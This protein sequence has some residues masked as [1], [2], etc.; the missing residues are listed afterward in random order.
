MAL[1]QG[2]WR[3]AKLWMGALLCVG[4]A[5]ATT[6]SVKSSDLRGF[7]SDG[8]AGALLFQRCEAGGPAATQMLLRDKSAGSLLIAG[9]GEVRRARQD[10]D[11]PLYVEFRGDVEEKGATA[12]QFYRAIGH[13]TSCTSLP[14]VQSGVQLL[15][16]GTQPA[17]R[18]QAT[19]AG[20]RLE[21]VGHKPV[22]FAPIKLT[23][24]DSA[25]KARS[26]QAA[27]VAGGERMSLELTEQACNDNAAEAAFGA[28]VTAQWGA[29]RLEGCAARF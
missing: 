24:N 26:Y 16:E 14:A 4:A 29:Q 12:L 11:Q 10:A 21:R 20:T 2:R 23:A 18:L 17:W 8:I 5:C 6:P 19:P 27:A 25:A 3:R 7:V 28:R 22:R 13:V 9:I 15:A 1:K